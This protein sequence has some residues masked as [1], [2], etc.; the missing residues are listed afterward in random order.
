MEDNDFKEDDVSEKQQKQKKQP[1]VNIIA[2][3]NKSNRNYV[4]NSMKFDEDKSDEIIGQID[5]AQ[6]EII[7][8]STL[9]IESE[10]NDF[11]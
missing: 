4:V 3:A 7:S 1:R 10:P 2:N 6:I 9:G 5:S 8:Y 11:W